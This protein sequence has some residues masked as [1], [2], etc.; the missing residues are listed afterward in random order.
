[1]PNYWTERGDCHGYPTIEILSS[2]GYP[3]DEHFRFGIEKSKLILTCFELI[4]TFSDS[5]GRL[6]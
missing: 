2:T 1:M 3:Y 5:E 6:N 4:G